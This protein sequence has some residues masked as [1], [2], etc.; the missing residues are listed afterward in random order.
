M[1]T[2][3][4]STHPGHAPVLMG[5]FPEQIVKSSIFSLIPLNNNLITGEPHRTPTEHKQPVRK[6]D[7]TARKVTRLPPRVNCAFWTIA[8]SA[9]RDGRYG[10]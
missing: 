1:S 7:T 5:A 6:I 2:V 10:K 3:L 4:L 8:G 9:D